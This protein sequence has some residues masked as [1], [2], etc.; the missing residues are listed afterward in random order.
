MLGTSYDFA[1]GV[2][3]P[4]VKALGEVG[5]MLTSDL[6]LTGSVGYKLGLPPMQVRIRLMGVRFIR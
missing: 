5:F 3:A 1:L 4:G 6:S 2:V